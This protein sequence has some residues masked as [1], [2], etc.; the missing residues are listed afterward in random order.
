M[1]VGQRFGR[2]EI[3]AV[4]GAG[5]MGEV[6]L[7]FDTNLRR[8]VALKI[9]RSD[10]QRPDAVARLMAEA[11]AAAAL[12]HAN[13]VTLL[14]AGEIDGVSYLAMEHIEGETLRAHVGVGGDAALKLDW[15][16]QVASALAAAHAA[17]IVHR[18]IKPDNVIVAKDGTVKVL[19][20]GIAKRIVATDTEAA[21]SDGPMSVR[22]ADGRIIG[23]TA[24]MAPEQLAG[25]EPTPKWDQ[26]AWG[27]TAFELL[28]GMRPTSSSAA[29]LS[30]FVP[31]VSFDVASLVAR[32]IARSPEERNAGMED[33]ARALGATTASLAPE[34]PRASKTVA[35]AAPVHVSAREKPSSPLVRVFVALAAFAV[36]AT[37]VAWRLL[38][39]PVVAPVVAASHAPEPNA[40]TAVVTA[41]DA[42]SSPGAAVSSSAAP[43]P[44]A[45][46]PPHARGL[47]CLCKPVS[48]PTSSLCAKTA[49]A[50]PRQCKCYAAIGGDLCRVPWTG[51]TSTAT[52][53]DH[54]FGNTLTSKDGDSCDGYSEASR[55]E[56]LLNP[57]AT[58]ELESCSP[59]VPAD[60]FAFYGP[61]GAPCVGYRNERVPIA[62]TIDCNNLRY[63][64]RN[65]NQAAC[66]QVGNK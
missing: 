53:S 34:P 10:S 50:R 5:G 60:V 28:S 58:G 29:L 48:G 23:T 52:C 37:A 7:A 54:V 64:C 45:S 44:S 61:E 21:T 63:D 25:G 1:E 12:R 66:A 24:Y 55:G 43:F 39:R 47:A 57:H 56:D 17:G 27:I 2:Y 33:I 42:P 38:H 18:D 32:A 46:A 36:G 35:T 19:D 20:F 11:R 4:I 30:T 3:R 9:V 8:N 49:L 26:F 14:D 31:G 15:L 22:T 51:T 16:R 40:S 6:L 62:G 41:P 59:C 65:G 13:V